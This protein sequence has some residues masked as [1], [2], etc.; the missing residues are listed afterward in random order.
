MNKRHKKESDKQ[1]SHHVQQF[2]SKAKALK[3]QQV[4]LARVVCCA[5]GITCVLY[6][7]MYMY[8]YVYIC[9]YDIVYNII[10]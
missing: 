3:T 10:W 8:M 9:V 4:E 1:E 2:R 6:M 5:G 7:H